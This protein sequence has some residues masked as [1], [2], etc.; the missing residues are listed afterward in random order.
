M[1]LW[2]TS[3]HYTP[4]TGPNWIR[5]DSRFNYQPGVVVRSLRE[6]GQSVEILGYERLTGQPL[7]WQCERAFL[8][9]GAIPTTRIL[10]CS[11]EAY[12]QTVSM[13]DSQYFLLPLLMF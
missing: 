4:K 11:L 10:L 5:A 2:K 12:D 1:I 6:T 3:F 13:K 8:A 7:V 9:A